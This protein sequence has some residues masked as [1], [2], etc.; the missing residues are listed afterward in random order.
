MFRKKTGQPL[1]SDYTDAINIFSV[2]KICVELQKH[3]IDKYVLDEAFVQK[4]LLDFISV[5]D[6]RNLFCCRVI[7]YYKLCL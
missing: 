3:L 7:I 1:P 2:S 5:M 4:N 6:V